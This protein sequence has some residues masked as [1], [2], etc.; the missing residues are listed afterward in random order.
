[1]VNPEEPDI[2]PEPEDIP[3]YQPNREDFL[4]AAWRCFSRDSTAG[5]SM[6]DVAR[7]ADS[8]VAALTAFFSDKDDLVRSVMLS[9]LGNF[10]DVVQSIADSPEGKTPVGF[11]SSMLEQAQEFGIRSD[12]VNRFRLVIQSWAYA[13]TD[14]TMAETIVVRYREFAA[15]YA[16]SA[17]EDWGF[18]E[19]EAEAISAFL[20][21]ALL[22]LTAQLGLESGAT[23]KDVVAALHDLDRS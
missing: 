9:S 17:R 5:T 6:E 7:E 21:S 19:M 13:Q 14:P 11:L 1:M 18:D 20:A 22:G 12:G 2:E 4:Q 23:A 8:S 10:Q 15:L 3:A 16:K